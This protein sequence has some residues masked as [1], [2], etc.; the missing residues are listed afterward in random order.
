[1]TVVITNGA[2]TVRPIANNSRV[3]I[4]YNNELREAFNNAN[5]NNLNIWYKNP[6]D[7]KNGGK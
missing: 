3:R 7:R 6:G 5:I 4:H 1:M 2:P